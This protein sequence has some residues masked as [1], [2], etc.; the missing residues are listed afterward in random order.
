MVD[1]TAAV[2]CSPA[3]ARYARQIHFGYRFLARGLDYYLRRTPPATDKCDDAIAMGDRRQQGDGAGAGADTTD[4]FAH[5]FNFTHE[6]A[7]PE[8][9]FVR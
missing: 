6:K 7:G 1:R 9:G 3:S 2:A 8:A 5:Y 4:N